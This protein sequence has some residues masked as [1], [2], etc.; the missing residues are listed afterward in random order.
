[1]QSS[2]ENARL[3]AFLVDQLTR[4]NGSSSSSPS[5]TKHMHAHGN[6]SGMDKDRKGARVGRDGS[7]SKALEF[8]S[9]TQHEL[10]VKLK[11]A[12]ARHASQMKQLQQQSSKMRLKLR[13]SFI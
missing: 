13:V 9:L 6:G 3:A 4:P 12:N 10:E 8:K 5:S 7:P 2:T 11:Y 1:M